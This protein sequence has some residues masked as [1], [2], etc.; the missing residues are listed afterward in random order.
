MGEALGTFAA[1]PLN[2]TGQARVVVEDSQHLGP[3]PAPLSD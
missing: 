3:D 1:V 2:V